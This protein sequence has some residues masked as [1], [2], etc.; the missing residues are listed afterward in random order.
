MNLDPATLVQSGSESGH[1]TA[2]LAWSALPDIRAK[3]PDLKWLFHIPNGGSRNKFEAVRLKAQG[4]KS[5][6]PDLCL[7]ILRGRYYG[8]WIE[9][10][11]IKGKVSEQQYEWISY[12]SQQGYY[13]CVC[14]G[15]EAAR[16]MLIW[17][18]E[19]DK[20]SF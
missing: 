7:P 17:Y 20:G 1:Q 6:V 10:K 16:D 3:Y 19:L 12:L 8:L 14:R 18:L 9:L 4:V 2:L 13:S 5:G 15:W 11:K